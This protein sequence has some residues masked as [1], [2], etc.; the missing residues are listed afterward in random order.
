MSQII[1]N[2][3]GVILAS[4]LVSVIVASVFVSAF[5][6]HPNHPTSDNPDVATS[7]KDTKNRDKWSPV[8]NAKVPDSSCASTSQKNAILTVSGFNFGVTAGSTIDG[9]KIAVDSDQSNAGSNWKIEVRKGIVYNGDASSS[10]LIRP[11]VASSCSATTENNGTVGGI[12]T[13]WGYEWTPADMNDLVISINTLTTTNSKRIDGVTATVYWTLDNQPPQSSSVLVSPDPTNGQFAP[14]IVTA[15]V[16]DLPNP[17]GSGVAGAEFYIDVSPGSFG[18]GTPMSITQGSLGDLTVGVSGEIAIFDGVTPLLTEGNHI[19]Y[20]RAV[21]VAGNVEATAS[22]T[23][24][25][26]YT[27]P[28]IFQPVSYLVTT[29]DADGSDVFYTLAIP[30]FTDNFD[31][32]IVVD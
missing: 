9:I 5:A 20:V 12:G 21:D 32:A 15:T 27:P 16:N 23:F 19:A 31:S 26:D 4:V 6:N 18:T 24:L 22:Y 11:T 7:N 10:A 29:P 28:T 3:Y 25:V 13:L 17:G 14:T 1:R 8:N 30:A 2:K